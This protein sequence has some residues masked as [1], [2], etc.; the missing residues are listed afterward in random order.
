MNQSQLSRVS[1][2]L[3]GMAI[4]LLLVGLVVQGARA[5]TVCE[6]CHA[7]ADQQ[8]LYYCKDNNLSPNDPRCVGMR[9]GYRTKECYES[10]NGKA[11]I[12]PD[13]GTPTGKVTC[14]SPE[15]RMVEPLN[16]PK[17][18]TDQGGGSICNNDCWSRACSD[19]IP[20]PNGTSGGVFS[21]R[22]KEVEYDKKNPPAGIYSSTCFVKCVCG[23]Q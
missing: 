7:W 14:N 23:D 10:K 8:A 3:G 13:G 16:C 1:A 15:C 17:Q 21:C 6:N 2:G 20:G 22:D 12:C 11:P 9:Q 19:P 4:A 18:F 5:A